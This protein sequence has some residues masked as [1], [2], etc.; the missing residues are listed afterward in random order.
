MII[1]ILILIIAYILEMFLIIKLNVK[2]DI[3]I[4]RHKILTNQSIGR[5]TPDFIDGKLTWQYVV[6]LI[7]P[8]TNVIGLIACLFM[9]IKYSIKI[10]RYNIRVKRLHREKGVV[11]VF[12]KEVNIWKAW[13]SW[14]EKF[15]QMDELKKLKYK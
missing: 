12:G 6:M 4:L 10:C 11:K 1:D 15:V 5:L 8:I 13:K 14:F 9:Y 3:L 7:I 2:A